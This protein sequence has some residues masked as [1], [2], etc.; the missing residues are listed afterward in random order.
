V[1]KCVLDDI[2]RLP[3]ESK[4]NNVGD[5]T[6]VVGARPAGRLV[7]STQAAPGSVDLAQE[8]TLDWIHWGL[9]DRQ[10]VNRKA[11]A[12]QIDDE[13]VKQGKGHRDRTPGCPLAVRW[14]GGTPTA[15]AQDSHSG[16]WWNGPGT[17]QRFSVAADTTER[18]LRVYA[19]GIGGAGCTL[20]AS[21][22]DDSAPA[23]LSTA[24]NGNAAFPWAAV[25]GNFS[26][27]YTLRYRA[28][29]AGQKLTV[30][31][32]LSSEPNRFL[33]QARLQAATL[34]AGDGGPRPA[35]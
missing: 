32:E 19:S 28:A 17:G 35:H 10:S 22:S 8:G 26:A 33:A 3:G 9:A 18:V 15:E 21:L 34:S 12:Q 31:W 27:V 25:P 23:Y 24:W 20:T 1:L 7:G 2:N 11:G 13:L 5:R 14:T 4:G 6:F 16:L 29:A 30:C